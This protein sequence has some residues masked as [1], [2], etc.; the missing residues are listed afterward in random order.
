MLSACRTPRRRYQA[1]RAAAAGLAAGLPLLLA[2]AAAYA[3]YYH[4][5]NY[6]LF[7]K[8]FGQNYY[9]STYSGSSYGDRPRPAAPAAPYYFKPQRKPRDTAKD[10][11]K[12]PAKTSKE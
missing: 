10:S 12:E 11:V 4:R 6:G 7:G 9:G 2:P 8:I 3:H 1:G 5:P